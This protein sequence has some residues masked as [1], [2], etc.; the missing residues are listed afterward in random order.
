MPPWR[1]GKKPACSVIFVPNSVLL[2]F[3]LRTE[4]CFVVI[5]H[6]W[7]KI[8]NLYNVEAKVWRFPVHART[9]LKTQ[10][11]ESKT[12]KESAISNLPYYWC[13]HFRK[14]WE[15]NDITVNE[16]NA[17]APVQLRM[18]IFTPSNIF[19]VAY[20]GIYKRG[21]L[22]AGQCHSFRSS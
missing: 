10:R 16:I 14:R 4:Q 1:K 18:G 13:K 9:E 5:W 15:V 7:P 17:L 11:D 19:P 6:I 21:W 8:E 12:M 2:C 3:V 22:P 20:T